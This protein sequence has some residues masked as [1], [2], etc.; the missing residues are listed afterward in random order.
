LRGNESRE[1]ASGA[2]GIIEGILI[3]IFKEIAEK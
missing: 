2:E 1:R 3:A